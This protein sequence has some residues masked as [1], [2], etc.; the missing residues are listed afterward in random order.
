[1]ITVRFCGGLLRRLS[2]KTQVCYRL[3]CLGGTIWEN[4]DFDWREMAR[5][6]HKPVVSPTLGGAHR[7]LGEIIWEI[8]VVTG[9]LDWSEPAFEAR[10]ILVYALDQRLISTWWINNVEI[11]RVY[12]FCTGSVF[13]AAWGNEC[14][15]SC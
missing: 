14:P 2:H 13:Y 12:A 5:N 6:S 7:W 15:G 9:D 10:I 1:M 8:R 11:S 3:R 4:S